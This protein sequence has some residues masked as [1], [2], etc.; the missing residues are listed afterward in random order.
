MICTR[1]S[2]AVALATR[3]TE[4]T[5]RSPTAEPLPHGGSDR[6]LLACET[7]AMEDVAAHTLGNAA[8]NDNELAYETFGNRAHRR[9]CSLSA[10]R[11]R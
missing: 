1:I 7:A 8:A 10:W 9:P 2:V 6:R 11:R 5:D 4:T 3:S